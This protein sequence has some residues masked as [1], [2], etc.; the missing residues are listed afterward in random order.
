MK[1]ITMILGVLLLS[2]TINVSAAEL[3][4]ELNGETLPENVTGVTQVDGLFGKG[5][6]LD[7]TGGVVINQNLNLSTGFSMSVWVNCDFKKASGSY[8]NLIAYSRGNLLRIM[9]RNTLDYNFNGWHTLKIEKTLQSNVWQ[10]WTITFDGKTLIAYVDGK[11]VAKVDPE[12][13]KIYNTDS[14]WLFFDDKGS[15]YI[16]MADEIK[17]YNGALTPEEVAKLAERPQSNKTEFDI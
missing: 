9:G 12:K 11:E 1:K 8:M 10:N 2:L 3:V 6:A 14:W 5:L 7:G 16:G 17:L 13:N 15:N 4:F